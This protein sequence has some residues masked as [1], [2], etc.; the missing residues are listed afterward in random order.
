MIDVPHIARR[1]LHR[2][3]GRRSGACRALDAR[4]AHEEEHAHREVSDF[5]GQLVGRR[6]TLDDD[7]ELVRFGLLHG[8]E[9]LQHAVL[10]KH[11]EVKL[12]LLLAEPFGDRGLAPFDRSID[13]AHDVRIAQADETHADL[14]PTGK[15]RAGIN[16]G[17][18]VIATRDPATG[19]P[20]GIAVNIAWEL[21]RRLDVPVEYV[22]FEQARNAVD[23][24]QAGAI[25]VVFVAIEPVRAA[26]I[27][28]TAPYAEIAGTYAVPPG[29]K[30]RTMD[31]IDRTGVRISVVARS[32]YDL[33]LTRTLKNAQLV[34]ANTTQ[35]SADEFIA[36]KVDALA[37]VKQ[38]VDD[39]VARTPGARVLDG[40]FMATAPI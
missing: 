39:A 19:N 36:G 38:R 10:A 30:I 2:F 22:V 25:D 29:S 28:F 12:V 6:E 37:G 7:T 4:D 15:L 32:N 26:V 27:D 13:V 11:V 35:G 34:R 18:G 16:L 8:L 5:R 24:M 40:R 1:R 17:N 23:A 3:L 20:R 21:G 33:F 9:L 31:E 14:V